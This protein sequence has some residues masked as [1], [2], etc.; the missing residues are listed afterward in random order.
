[1]VD[2]DGK[3]NVNSLKMF[4]SQYNELKL[5][6]FDVPRSNGDTLSSRLILRFLMTG[7]GFLGME[8]STF[9]GFLVTCAKINFSANTLLYWNLLKVRPTL[10]KNNFNY[11]VG[12][13]Y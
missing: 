1:M 7:S 10:I 6:T 2:H 12:F 3:I 11:Y 13:G 9:I 4:K 8:A 5:S